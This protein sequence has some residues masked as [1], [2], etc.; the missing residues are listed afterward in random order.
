VPADCTRAIESRDVAALMN[1][2]AIVGP[3]MA[4]PRLFDRARALEKRRN[5]RE[6]ARVAVRDAHTCTQIAQLY[7]ART[8]V[9][10]PNNQ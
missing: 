7:E 9:R 5:G 10:K 1:E 2:K 6:T 3:A 8:P 4:E